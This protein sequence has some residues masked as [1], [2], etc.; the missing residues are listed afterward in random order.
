MN[1]LI[2]ERI[3]ED[4]LGSDK[5]TLADILSANPANPSLIPRQKALKSGNLDLLYLYENKLLLIELRVVP[6]YH[7]MIRQLDGYFE[8]LR[9][10]Q[11]QHRV[12]SAPITKVARVAAAA[13]MGWRRCEGWE[14]WPPRA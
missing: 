1:D 13:A 14:C 3:V 11:A 7:D 6:F 9:D 12:I 4:I 5:S 8:H 2:S 10:L